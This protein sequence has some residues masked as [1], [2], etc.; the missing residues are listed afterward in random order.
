M[1]PW[2]KGKES[3]ESKQQ[4]KNDEEILDVMTALVG[5]PKSHWMGNTWIP[6]EGYR[7]YTTDEMRRIF[8]HENTLFAGDSLQRRVADTLCTVLT[9]RRQTSMYSEKTDAYTH[10]HDVYKKVLAKEK[11]FL[12]DNKNLGY[13]DAFLPPALNASGAKVAF[14]WRPLLKQLHD[15]FASDFGNQTFAERYVNVTLLIVSSTI[16]DVHLSARY[17]TS[18]QDIGQQMK[19]LVLK[20]HK[21]IP[22][23][24]LVVFKTAGWCSSCPWNLTEAKRS[25]AENQKVYAANHELQKTVAALQSPNR[26]TID[27]AREVLPRSIGN[28]KIVAEDDN[29]YHYGIEG[30]LQ[31]LQMLTSV[32]DGRKPEILSHT[33]DNTVPVGSKRQTIS[34]DAGVGLPAYLNFGL[35]LE[36]VVLIFAIVGIFRRFC[37]F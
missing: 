23:N 5:E 28:F 6:Q 12:K 25:V 31:F 20:L 22:S 1:K 19:E 7:L 3:E 21:A 15:D 34:Q 35:E 16:W 26:I 27:W 11:C 9:T 10:T 2:Q 37:R 14:D 30:R 13:E 24:T 4:T 36:T 33:A 29:P 32:L 17:H 8:Q 18:A